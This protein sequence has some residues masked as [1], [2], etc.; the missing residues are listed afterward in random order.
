[1]FR[2]IS[3]AILGGILCASSVSAA[4]NI[5][6]QK[7]DIQVPQQFFIKYNGQYKSSVP[8]GFP[9]GIGSGMTYVGKASDGALVFY[10]IGDR[11]PNADV[12]KFND[13]AGKPHPTK[14]F[15]APAFHPSYG[16]VRVKDGKAEIA[17]LIQ[18]KDTKGLPISGRPLP[19]GV[20]GSTNEIP[21]SDSL[22][23]L[24]TD[25]EG[26]DTEGIA[27]D[28]HNKRNLWICDEYGP[29]I[30][31]I[32]GYTGRIIKKYTPG[33]ELPE[34]VAK[35]QPNRGFEGIAVT[36]NNTVIAAVQ[37][38]CDVDGKVKKSKAAFTRLVVLNPDT[39]KTK[40]L[41]F[42]L[43]GYY[44]SNAAAKIGDLHAISDNKLLIIE[45]GKD[46]DKKMHNS[47]YLIDISDA[48]DLTG[49]TAPD[50]SP[51]ETLDGLEALKAQ[52]IRPVA[53]VKLLDLRD[54]GW[55][56]GKAEGLALLPDRRT[57]AVCS[58]ND[59]GFKGVTEN[60]AQDENGKPVK[61]ATQYTVDAQKTVK[62]KGKKVNT[63]FPIAL[64]GENGQLWLLTLP[65]TIDKY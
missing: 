8:E 44:K 22:N 2:F 56:P 16:A 57:L 48:T 46:K 37:S 47:I 26:M 40:M 65:K 13:G 49:K 6:V 31:Q 12:P 21:L 45:Q 58:D 52:G 14:M 7:Y 60:P 51:L 61:K 15:P 63:T 41:A 18:I 38:I 9:M 50:G 34:I 33:K 19:T 17:S 4:Q 64:T 43:E 35:R 54:Y 53:K 3:A 23:V 28:R 32:D 62:Y 30:A 29:F 36:P 5:D 39:G 20:V 11:G 24:S 59:F 25:T 10:C 55:T 42:P 1:M 27:I